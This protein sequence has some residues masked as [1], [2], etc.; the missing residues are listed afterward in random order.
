MRFKVKQSNHL[1]QCK[2]NVYMIKNTG[3]DSLVKIKYQIKSKYSY[4]FNLIIMENKYKKGIN[5]SEYRDGWLY[6]NENRLMKHL[7]QL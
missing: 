1:N 2:N 5:N 7:S 4:F 6:Q 3:H